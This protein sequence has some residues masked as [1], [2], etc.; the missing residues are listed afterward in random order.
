MNLGTVK[1]KKN[2]KK[3]SSSLK[4][5]F[6]NKHESHVKYNCFIR[7]NKRTN[8]CCNILTDSKIYNMRIHSVRRSMSQGSEA[9][10]TQC[11]RF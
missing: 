4:R 8:H 9:A 11:K 2:G 6:N 5:L 1:V 10:V 3:A 7:K